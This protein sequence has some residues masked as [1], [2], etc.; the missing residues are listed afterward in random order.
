MRC[1]V[2]CFSRRRD[3]QRCW[4]EITSQPDEGALPDRPDAAHREAKAA[5]DIEIALALS[6]Q[7]L[8]D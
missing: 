5:G 2:S 8:D 7:H 4:P 3:I 1:H 6:F